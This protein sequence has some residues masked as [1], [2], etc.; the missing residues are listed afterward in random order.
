M[1]S[2]LDIEKIMDLIVKNKLIINTILLLWFVIFII[3]ILIIA[4]VKIVKNKN[5][6]GNNKDVKNENI[7]LINIDKLREAI[8]I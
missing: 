1:S 7:P 3:I 6:L 2:I 8:S 4:Y 5:I